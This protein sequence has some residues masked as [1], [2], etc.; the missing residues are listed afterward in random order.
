MSYKRVVRDRQK[1]ME[2]KRKVDNYNCFQ[3]FWHEDHYRKFS[4]TDI[5]SYRDGKKINRKAERQK[6]KKTSC[7]VNPA[8]HKKLTDNS[9]WY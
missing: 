2:K 3:V 6:L 7:R 1:L 8:Y 5:P 4:L 9:V